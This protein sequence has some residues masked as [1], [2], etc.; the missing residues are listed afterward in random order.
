MQWLYLYIV[1][2]SYILEACLINIDQFH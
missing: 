2:Q 1:L